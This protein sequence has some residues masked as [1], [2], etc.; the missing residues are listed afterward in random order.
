VQE[1]DFT[2]SSF[3]EKKRI[4]LVDQNVDW[5]EF[6]AESLAAKGYF[7]LPPLSQYDKF[8][9][10]AYFDGNPHDL[11]ILGCARIRQ[12]ELDLIQ[13]VKNS[14]QLLLV[15][16]AFLS[17]D[18]RRSLF[19]KNVDVADKPFD[20]DGLVAAVEDAFK[21]PISEPEEKY[22]IVAFG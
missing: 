2:V 5:L 22:L 18:D 13:K 15:L 16:C 19:R 4:L 1:S 21:Y 20:I 10:S 8:P 9:D 7:V 3:I 6:A 12:P 14:K 11:V 17:W